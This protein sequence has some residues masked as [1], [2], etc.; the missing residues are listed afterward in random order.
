MKLYGVYDEEKISQLLSKNEHKIH[1]LTFLEIFKLFLEKTNKINTKTSE[2][3]NLLL[4]KALDS[5][6][7]SQRSTFE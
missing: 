6:F 7:C 5:I 2:I 3:L 4:T 1:N